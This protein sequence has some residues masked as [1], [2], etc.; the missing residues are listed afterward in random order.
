MIKLRSG[1]DESC[2]LYVLGRR[3][4]EREG[5]SALF[6]LDGVGWAVKRLLQCGYGAERSPLPKKKKKTLGPPK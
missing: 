6:S 2:V 4:G 3:E 1:P 5:A